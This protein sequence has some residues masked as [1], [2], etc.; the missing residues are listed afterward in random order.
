MITVEGTNI[1]YTKDDNFNWTLPISGA[2]TD[3]ALRFIISSKIT[4]NVESD[5][6]IDNTYNIN[7]DGE[8]VTLKL[9]DSDIENLLIG[10][11]Y[12]KMIY[13]NSSRERTTIKSG[14]FKVK[15]GA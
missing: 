10:D 12:Y 1:T 15:W 2:T 6:T 7:D 11:Y 5:Y 4:D 8:S 13:I 9:S 14:Q 3:D